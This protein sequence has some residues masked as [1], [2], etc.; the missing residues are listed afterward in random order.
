MFEIPISSRSFASESGESRI[1]DITL[2][3]SPVK[4]DLS[5]LSSSYLI[6]FWS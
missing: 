5:T 4:S 1:G 2:R 3:F 6:L